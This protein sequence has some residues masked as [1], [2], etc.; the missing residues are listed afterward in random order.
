VQDANHGV[1]WLKWRA[2]E[3]NGDPSKLGVYGSSSGGHVA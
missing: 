3:W 1:R 2:A